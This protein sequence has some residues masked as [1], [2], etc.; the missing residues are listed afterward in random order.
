MLAPFDIFK[1]DETGHLLWCGEAHTLDDAK[2]KIQALSRS[3]KTSFVIF[4]QTT[5]KRMI[6]QPDSNGSHKWQE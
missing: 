2:L 5:G 3:H 4:S 6:V 1:T